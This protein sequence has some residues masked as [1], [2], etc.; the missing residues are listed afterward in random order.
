[1]EWLNEITSKFEEAFN[2]SVDYAYAHPKA[3]LVVVIVLLSAGLM[4]GSC[5]HRKPIPTD[6]AMTAHFMAN[7]AAFCELRDSI[8][9]LRHGFYYPPFHRDMTEE[10]EEE[11]KREYEED[12]DSTISTEKQQ[13]MDSLLRV[14]GCERVRYTNAEER[15]AGRTMCLT[16]VYWSR[17]YS[18]G[19]TGKNYVYCPELPQMVTH[20]GHGL[21][22]G[23]ETAQVLDEIAY[24]DTTVYRHITSDWYIKLEHD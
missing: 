12:C 16:F 8:L 21:V 22:E 23:K 10:Y 13:R 7:K 2:A 18:I 24:R 15:E 5:I 17:G 3:G 20:W 6:E 4:L 1:M 19:G 9:T 14:T 11:L